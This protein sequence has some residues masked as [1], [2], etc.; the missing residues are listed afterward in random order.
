ML[1]GSCWLVQKLCV[2]VLWCERGWEALLLL[3]QTLFVE[4]V[5]RRVV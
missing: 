1:V 3:L 4:Y 2:S 5:M